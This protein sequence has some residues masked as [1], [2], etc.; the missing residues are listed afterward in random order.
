MA[1]RR[2]EVEM[3]GSKTKVPAVEG[4]FTLDE[5][6]PA[7]LG[8]RCQ[9]CGTY[10][11]PAERAFCKNPYCN[12]SEFDEVEL[13]RRGTVWSYTDAQYQPPALLSLSPWPRWSW[14]LSRWW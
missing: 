4:W 5:E 11:F 9:G 1:G 3:A 10:A 2:G 12:S 13:S 6:A 14:R 7:L 8:S